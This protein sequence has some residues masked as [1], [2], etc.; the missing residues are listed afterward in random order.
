MHQKLLRSQMNP[1][2]IFNALIAI[3]NYILKNKKFEASDYLSQFATLM[4]AILEG[5]RD[6]FILLSR[7]IELLKYYVSLQQ[8]RF[9]N[10]FMFNLEL[11]EK[12]NAD[13]LKIP[14]M[15]LQPFVENAIEHGLRELND[16]EKTLL[17]KYTLDSK[18]LCI[19]IIDN[20]IGIKNNKKSNTNG[21]QSYAMKITKERLMNITKIYKVNIDISIRDLSEFE[22]EYGTEI[23]FLIPIKLLKGNND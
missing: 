3:Q 15:I 2:F 22:N 16:K 14:P 12:I 11:D 9:E 1:H 17:V 6:D 19:K 10:S 5:S 4:R 18:N 13:E 8:L 21:H 23:K 20:G 7:E